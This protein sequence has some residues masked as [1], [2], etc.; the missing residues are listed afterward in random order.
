M[1]R[2]ARA[3]ELAAFRE[4]GALEIA[5]ARR[6]FR[7]SA[8]RGLDP[9][10]A[11]R[12]AAVSVRRA[13]PLRAHHGR[14]V[15]AP[16]ARTSKTSR[17]EAG[18]AL[19]GS[20]AVC[21][22]GTSASAWAGAGVLAVGRGASSARPAVPG[23]AGRGRWRGSRSARQHHSRQRR[24]HSTGPRGEHRAPGV[25]RCRSQGRCGQRRSRVDLRVGCSPARARQ[26]KDIRLRKMPASSR[27]GQGRAEYDTTGKC[28]HHPR[29]SPSRRAMSAVGSQAK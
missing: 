4:V 24:V 25:D 15:P 20:T 13:G 19:R 17:A 3:R 9:N 23:P 26:Y 8:R 6:V 14:G 21:A 22:S 18:D 2:R 27:T 1:S 29:R 12:R 10:G 11:F 7:V 5:P 28:K 16:T